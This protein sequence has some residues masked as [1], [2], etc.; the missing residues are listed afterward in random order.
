MALT[1]EDALRVEAPPRPRSA[2]LRL[3][4][5]TTLSRRA[6]GARESSAKRD[7]CANRGQRGDATYALASACETARHTRLAPYVADM[8]RARGRMRKL[9][10]EQRK[11]R[12]ADKAAKA[13]GSDNV[14][15]RRARPDCS[16]SEFN[17]VHPEFLG[18][19]HSR[20]S[21]N[22]EEPRTRTV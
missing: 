2:T 4:R 14:S 12:E 11:Q 9:T 8:P 16:S 21:E 17:R 20:D 3:G 22:S 18:V 13:A 5:P 1:N 15:P 6:R 19:K 10:A 7:R